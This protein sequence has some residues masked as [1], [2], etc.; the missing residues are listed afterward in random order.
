M[1]MHVA[2]VLPGTQAIWLLL[3]NLQ[4]LTAKA[5]APQGPQCPLHP[6]STPHLSREGSAERG[7]NLHHR[8]CPAGLLKGM[9]NDHLS[10]QSFPG[11]HGGAHLCR[12][13][14]QNMKGG[15]YT[16][17]FHCGFQAQISKP[18]AAGILCPA[19]VLA[20]THCLRSLPTHTPQCQVP[21]AQ[22]GRAGKRQ[23][24]ATPAPQNLHML[25]K[26]SV[27]VLIALFH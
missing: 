10:P 3:G 23:P 20:G 19:Q 15:L 16:L 1:R 22:S 4:T 14:G 26:V 5:L 11:E 24:D 13:T 27:F 12:P 8:W 25:F 17:P 21:D 9:I 6:A 18:A 7:P 2:H